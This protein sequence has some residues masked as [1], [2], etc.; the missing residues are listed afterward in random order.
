MNYVNVFVRNSLRAV[1]TIS[2]SFLLL[3]SLTAQNKQ[4]LVILLP[5]N[6]S[7]SEA[8]CDGSFEL[9]YF[10]VNDAKLNDGD[11]VILLTGVSTADAQAGISRKLYED[12]S[13]L[14]MKNLYSL[15]WS[16]KGV[17]SAL[18]MAG[19]QSVPVVPEKMKPDKNMA[20]PLSSFYSVM[21]TGEAREGKQ[22]RKINLGMRAIWKIYF[23]PE[24]TNVS[25]TLFTHAAEEKSVGVW[26][27]YLKKTNGYRSGEANS[28]MREALIG[29]SQ[30]D[31]AE[32]QKGKYGSAE[33]A[34]SKA[35]RAKGVKNDDVVQQLLGNIGLAK[36]KVDGQRKQVERLLAERRWDDAVNEAEP[37]KV[38]LSGWP[39]LKTIYQ[40]ALK[41]SHDLH[42]NR[43]EEAL[44][45]NQ[46]DVA[47]S[48]CSLA[49]QRL[50]ESDAARACVCQSRIRVSL[51]DARTLRQQRKPK[52][53]TELLEKQLSD[54][55][56]SRDENIAKELTE[57]K[58][59]YSNQ[60]VAEALRL[61]PGAVSAVKTVAVKTKGP[62]ARRPAPPAAARANAGQI[63]TNFREARAKL[64]L[65]RDVSDS[66]EIHGLLETVN[67]KLAGFC[68]DEAR[69]ANQRS[70]FGTAYVYLRSA[71][72]YTP[73]DYA[74]LSLLDEAREKFSNQIRVSIGFVFEN[75]SRNG[76]GDWVIDQVAGVVDSISADVGLSQPVVLDRRDAANAL[77]LIRSGRGL[78]SSTVVFSGDLLSLDVKITRNSRSVP[79]S[80]TYENPSWKSADREH[81][82]ADHQ[83]KQCRKQ[84]GDAACGDLRSRVES[85]R[86]YRDSIE[87][88]PRQTYSYNEATYQVWGNLRM[89][90][91]YSDSISRSIKSSDSLETGIKVDCIA[92]EGVHERDGTARNQRCDTI[93]DDGGY[94]RQ[95]TDD[96]RNKVQLTAAAQLIAMPFGYYQRAGANS[97]NKQK[98]IEDYIK[99]LFLAKEKNGAEAQT[100]RRAMAAFDVDLTTD[101]L[102]R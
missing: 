79:S 65:A 14:R 100:A 78:S 68:V 76:N 88:Y 44:R 53:A 75:K 30:A 48:D 25:D 54:G 57:S 40:S 89:S 72:D 20:P 4:A 41:E 55:D 60:L 52:E 70:E 84:S 51:R 19:Q 69:K 61:I 67:Q 97:I 11:E 74:V 46:L 42:L 26:D 32:F 73:N 24:G 35:E 62:A 3:T 22:K 63:R 21:L 81:D 98:A 95:M 96:I 86:A 12:S 1:L 45:N 9:N 7:V 37:I 102:L 13:S 77:S 47:K 90:F 2:L 28:S 16:D 93:S 59:E 36:Q 33:Q 99:F 71:Q 43:G 50:P 8:A 56:C 18:P 39:E 85:L 66:E 58:R 83:Y 92:R 101:G 29:C 80:Y 34:R 91:L 31:L 10:L 64:L 5:T 38:Y 27:A 23:I 15:F 17:L 6:T 87:H 82:A 49:W 94:I